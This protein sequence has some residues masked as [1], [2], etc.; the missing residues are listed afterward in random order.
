MHHLWH[1]HFYWTFSTFFVYHW[2][3]TLF[4]TYFLYLSSGYLSFLHTACHYLSY[5]LYCVRACIAAWLAGY[6]SDLL[7]YSVSWAIDN[8]W[9]VCH[10]DKFVTILDEMFGWLNLKE[11]MMFKPIHVSSC[12]HKGPH[13]SG[14]LTVTNLRWSIVS[15][16]S[17]VAVLSSVLAVLDSI[18]A[19]CCS[20]IVLFP[21]R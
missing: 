6:I 2:W 18:H 9:T 20:I 15:G 14:R 12:V 3:Y 17:G 7:Q 1:T 16:T 5:L 8:N 19:F 11:K 21:I 10:R 4:S 13:P